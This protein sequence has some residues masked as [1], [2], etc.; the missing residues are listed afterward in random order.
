MK[1]QIKITNILASAL[2]STALASATMFSLTNV[3]KA[4]TCDYGDEINTGSTSSCVGNASEANYRSNAIGANSRAGYYSNALGNGSLA[5]SNDSYNWYYENT[6]GNLFTTNAPGGSLFSGAHEYGTYRY[7]QVYGRQEF[8]SED[9]YYYVDAKTS[10]DGYTGKNF[11]RDYLS[12]SS[13]LNALYSPEQI[14]AY[15]YDIGILPNDNVVYGSVA[16]GNDSLAVR[17]S[18]AVG[19][20]AV[21][22]NYSSATGTAAYA[23]EG[24]VANGYYSNAVNGS[25]ASGYF[26]YAEDLSVASGFNSVAILGSTAAGAFSSATGN[27]SVAI[28][29]GSNAEANNSVA[30]GANSNAEANNSVAL[31]ANS[32]ANR[33][34][35]VSVGSAGSERQIT[36]VAP[37]TQGTDAVNVNQLTKV[38]EK[39]TAGIAMAMAM[40]GG[41]NIP[42]GKNNAFTMAVGAFDSQQALAASYTTVIGP[43]SQLNA[44]VGY[45]G[46]GG[47]NE[48]QLGARIGATYSW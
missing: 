16:I 11:Y 42:Q 28:G 30:L 31:G 36:N 43:S 44:S 3:A 7:N 19:D 9:A 22:L 18:A 23:S 38:K 37:G 41:A 26:S 27:N 32:Y 34:N 40:G 4:V 25:V 6:D 48:T 2:V 20:S 29:Y 10:T 21:A 47:S 33:P 39:A 8:I 15:G 17:G 46:F 13:Q 35:T 45:S 14:I 1:K 12:N 5:I 24:S